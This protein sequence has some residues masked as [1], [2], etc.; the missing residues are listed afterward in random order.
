MLYVSKD[1]SFTG[2]LLYFGTKQVF[3]A[4][5][6][7][8]ESYPVINNKY[9]IYTVNNEGHRNLFTTL[10]VMAGGY[11]WLCSFSVCV[12]NAFYRNFEDIE[13]I[14]NTALGDIPWEINEDRI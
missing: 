1:I 9:A 8:N 5:P 6:A 7:L 13:F 2:G 4:K 12:D 3:T 11:F 14:L 10:D